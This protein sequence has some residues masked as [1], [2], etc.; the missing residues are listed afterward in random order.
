MKRSVRALRKL[1]EVAAKGPTPDLNEPHEETGRRSGQGC[2]F[3]EWRFAET[4]GRRDSGERRGAQ[5]LLCLLKPIEW[6]GLPAARSGSRPG[7]LLSSGSRVAHTT[8]CGR[9]IC[10]RPGLLQFRPT[11]VRQVASSPACRSEPGSGRHPSPPRPADPDTVVIMGGT[12]D[13]C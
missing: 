1:L 6:S 8:A 2:A 4:R 11:P 13:L 9:R 10:P 12:H 7:P 5:G 3:C